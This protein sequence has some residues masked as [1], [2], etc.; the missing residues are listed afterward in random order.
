MGAREGLE[1]GERDWSGW[2]MERT[3]RE[4]ERER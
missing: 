2:V 4:R 3:E 1:V